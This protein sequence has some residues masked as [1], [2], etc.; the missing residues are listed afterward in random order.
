MQ[1]FSFLHQLGKR[2]QERGPDMHIIIGLL[3][4]FV[5]VAFFARRNRATRNCRWRED[6]SGDRGGLRKYK[7]AA[8]GAETFTSAKTPPRECKAH[9]QPPAQ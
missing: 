2:V 3:I 1:A 5:I 4:A 7:C 6:H 9:T 8:C